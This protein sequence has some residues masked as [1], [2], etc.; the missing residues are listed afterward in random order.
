MHISSTTR[1]R[2][3]P[4]V[5]SPH[6]DFG[7][8]EFTDQRTANEVFMIKS[9]LLCGKKITLQYFKSKESPL[10]EQAPG[11]EGGGCQ[12]YG[13]PAEDLQ[14]FRSGVVNVHPAHDFSFRT[15]SLM[16]GVEE[17]M[18]IEKRNPPAIVTPSRLLIQTQTFSLSFEPSKSTTTQRPRKYKDYYSSL[19]RYSATRSQ[20]EVMGASD[21]IR[22]NQQI[23]HCSFRCQNLIVAR[24]P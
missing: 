17:A 16:N 20:S 21:N 3:R 13:S 18:K 19:Q 2:S 15:A 10:H 14:V 7:Y 11:P 9:H 22:F 24:Q 23:A 6:A 4:K 8:I 5:R 12:K 1:F